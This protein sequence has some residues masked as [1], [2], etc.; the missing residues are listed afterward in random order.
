M[1]R[2]LAPAPGATIYDP[3]CGSAGLLIHCFHDLLDR[4]AERQGNR[5]QAL[6]ALL[7]SLLE[8]LMGGARRVPVRTSENWHPCKRVTW[9]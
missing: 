4:H 5:W 1:A 6:D 9:A 2:I 7:K 8:Q 3:A